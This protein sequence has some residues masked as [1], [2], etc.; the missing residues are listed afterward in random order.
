M[1]SSMKKKYFLSLFFILGLGLLGN[2]ASAQETSA[3]QKSRVIGVFIMEDL[4]FKGLTASSEA[5]LLTKKMQRVD[6]E[7]VNPNAKGSEPSA[8]ASRRAALLQIKSRLMEQRNK[9]NTNPSKH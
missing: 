7:I 8:E 6:Q 4:L 3:C 5:E 1:L 9:L 2:R